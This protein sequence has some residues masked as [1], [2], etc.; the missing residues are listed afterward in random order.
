VQPNKEQAARKNCHPFGYAL[1]DR[2]PKR[3]ELDNVVD[4]FIDMVNAF[5]FG[6]Q[7]AL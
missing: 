1:G 6:P 4:S 7:R 2:R 5:I 3:L